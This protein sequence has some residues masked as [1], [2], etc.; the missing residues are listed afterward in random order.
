M[1]SIVLAKEAGLP[2]SY[3]G[4]VLVSVDWD[5]FGFRA[6]YQLHIQRSADDSTRIG[7]G[8]AP[9]I[10][11]SRSRVDVHARRS[12]IERV[13]NGLPH[14]AHARHRRLGRNQ[15]CDKACRVPGTGRP[16]PARDAARRCRA[17]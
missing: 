14:R 3:R 17:A 12:G 13:S 9:C 10:S 2:A 7:S 4:A 5:D 1:Q 6:M 15:C 11:R 16:L 8:M